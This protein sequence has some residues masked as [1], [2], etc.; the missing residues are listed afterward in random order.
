MKQAYYEL[1]IA[2]P[3]LDRLHELLDE[4]RY[5]GREC[6]D[7]ELHQGAKVVLIS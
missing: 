7:D 1:R 2:R 6:E 4:N 5:S 3:L